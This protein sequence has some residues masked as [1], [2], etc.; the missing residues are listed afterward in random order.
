MAPAP[1]PS[2]AP[3]PGSPATSVAA[4]AAPTLQTFWCRPNWA[5]AHA[6]HT[7]AA[8]VGSLLAV[9]HGFLGGA[10]ILAALLCVL[11][12]WLTGYSPGRRLTRERASQNVVSRAS[13]PT[14]TR[15]TRLRTSASSSPR[16]TTPAAPAWPTAT[17]CACRP[18][19]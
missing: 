13:A 18:R 1:T 14:T 5:L 2:A 15:A 9:H 17:G 11:G 3:P 6:S 12:D 10:I 8:I 19:A 16:T 7:L 4:G